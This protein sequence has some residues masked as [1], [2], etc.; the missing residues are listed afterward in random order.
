MGKIIGIRKEDKNIWEV[1]TPIIPEHVKV[2]KEKYDIETIVEDFERRV[3]KNEEYIRFGAKVKDNLNECKAIFAVKEIPTEKILPNKIYIFFAHVIKGQPY[4]MGMLKDLMDKKCTLID[5]ECIKDNTEKR[6]VFFG[7]YAGYA[8][9]IDALHGLGKRLKSLG[10]SNLLERISSAFN[11]HDVNEAKGVIESVGKEI[12]EIGL[13]KE[14]APYVFG[15]TGY[16]NVSNGAQEIFD[17]LPFEEITPEEL[18]ELSEY[19]NKKLYKVIFREEHMVKPSHPE[20]SFDLFDYFKHPEKYVPTFDKYLP[21]LSVI[22]NAVYWDERYPRLLTK[23][24]LRKNPKQKLLLISDISCDIN[25]SIEITYKATK[26]DNPAY[27]YNPF[28]DSF[29]DGFDGD[30]IVDMAVDNLPT[31]LPRD[32]SIAFSNALLPFINNIATAD[33]SRNFN[34]AGFF[35]EIKKAVIVYKGELTPNYEYLKSHL[36]K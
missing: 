10:R 33:L 6:L 35:D 24:Y 14:Y 9:M 1:R 17:L 31:E 12:K 3:F 18:T 30:G 25:G 34:E 20:N 26:P 36:P 15:F 28:T 7:K 13:P 21:Y 4:N 23:E 16:G 32:S 27:V 2:L 11:Y 22:V 19:D 5:Y 8:G 29:N